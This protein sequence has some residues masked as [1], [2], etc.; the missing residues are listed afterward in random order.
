[1]SCDGET[2][3]TTVRKVTT[4]AKRA[5]TRPTVCE[6]SEATRNVGN[7]IPTVDAGGMERIKGRDGP[8]VASTSSPVR[9]CRPARSAHTWST[10]GRRPCSRPPSR[11]NRPP[12]SLQYAFC[13]PGTAACRRPTAAACSGQVT[14]APTQGHHRGSLQGDQRSPSR[15]SRFEGERYEIDRRVGDLTS[16]EK[17]A[18]SPFS[19]S[20]T[21]ETRHSAESEK[22]GRVA[23]A[24][25][26]HSGDGAAVGGRRE[27]A[28]LLSHTHGGNLPSLPAYLCGPDDAR[29]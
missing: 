25:M 10:C 26:R 6:N 13:W 20:I 24:A 21:A 1:M 3:E 2:V 4:G 11:S 16:K 9:L 17:A 28:S 15:G 5:S 29:G 18:R 19:W 7:R 23:V 22:R 12:L 14:L 8:L 27:G